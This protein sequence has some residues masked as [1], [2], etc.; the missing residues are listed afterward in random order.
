M[1]AAADRV[2][3]MLTARHFARVSLRNP[4]FNPHNLH[5]VGCPLSKSLWIE[6]MDGLADVQ[7]GIVDAAVAVAGVPIRITESLGPGPC[8]S[9]IPVRQVS[10]MVINVGADGR[11]LLIRHEWGGDLIWDVSLSLDESDG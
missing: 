4:E 1:V 10:W 8:Y 7:Q 3:A 11:S 5:E 6:T 9:P 2:A